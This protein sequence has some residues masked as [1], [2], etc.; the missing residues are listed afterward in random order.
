VLSSG[1]DIVTVG[2][3]ALANPDLPKVLASKREPKTFDGA[4]LHPVASIKDSE[5]AM[6]SDA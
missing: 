3:G 4:I 1:A 6:L 2:R 5:L